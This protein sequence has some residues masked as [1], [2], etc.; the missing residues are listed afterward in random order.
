MIVATGARRASIVND[1][2]TAV[3]EPVMT[4]ERSI[5]LQPSDPEARPA[6]ATVE[7]LRHFGGLMPRALVGGVFTPWADPL[8][9]IEV[10]TSGPGLSSTPTGMSQLAKKRLTPGLADEFAP[11]V[12]EGTARRALP[13]GR[14]VVDRAAFDAV[15]SSAQAFELAAELL[16]V[17]LEAEALG[18]DASSV[19]RDIVEVSKVSGDIYFR[20]EIE[21]FDR[22]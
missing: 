1:E 5:I 4:I 14:V 9:L 7:I 18:N 16:A 2:P 8:L 11:S 3:F 13:G 21:T 12:V 10:M 15:E 22:V 19:A 20:E 6:R 17:V